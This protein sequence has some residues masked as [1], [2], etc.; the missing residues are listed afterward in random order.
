MN[1]VSIILL[2]HW[3][4]EALVTHAYHVL[5]GNFIHALHVNYSKM[6]GVA[7]SYLY[8]PLI[9]VWWYMIIFVI[10]SRCRDFLTSA[11]RKFSPLAGFHALVHK[12]TGFW[13]RTVWNIRTYY[14]YGIWSLCREV[15]S[16]F[17]AN[18]AKFYLLSKVRIKKSIEAMTSRGELQFKRLQKISLKKIQASIRFEPRPPRY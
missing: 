17:K 10:P 7:P 15:T 9:G 11:D 18:F 14:Q 16:L 1:T 8:T 2:P 3:S 13:R 12:T 6:Q 5:K 4:K